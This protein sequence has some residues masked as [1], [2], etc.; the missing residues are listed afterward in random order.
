MAQSTHPTSLLRLPDEL[1][2]A[3]ASDVGELHGAAG[4]VAFGRS[5]KRTHKLT[6]DPTLWKKLCL[7]R[8]KWWEPKHELATKAELPPA[9][10]D[11][12]ALYMERHRIDSGAR[13][14]FD[15]LL[16]TQHKRHHRMWD[17]A[18]QLRDVEDVLQKLRVEAD[19]DADAPLAKKY[20]AEAILGLMHRRQAIE[21][22]M[23]MQREPVALERALGAFDCFVFPAEEGTFEDIERKL[24]SIAQRI[25]EEYDA[26]EADG[27]TAAANFDD[28]SV[29]RKV[30]RI[31][32]FLAAHDHVGIRP[33]HLYHALQNSF[34]GVGLS[35]P[36]NS[37]LPLQ[38][39]AI[40]SAVARRLGVEADPCSFPGHIHLV[41]R[42]PP[43]QS[44]DGEQ[45]QASSSS[46]EADSMYMD[47][48]K[49][50]VEV[51]EDF[52][53]QVLSR[54][55]I[56]LDQHAS[57][58]RPATAHELV[59]RTGRNILTS[60]N[61]LGSLVP[62]GAVP[63]DHEQASYAM[64][65]SALVCS[66]VDMAVAARRQIIVR[67]ACALI[68]HIRTS[69]PW[70]VALLDL[71]WPTPETGMRWIAEIESVLGDLR[72]SDLQPKTPCPRG[73]DGLAA[74]EDVKYRVG[75]YIRHRHYHYQ[76]FI[77]GWDAHCK[78]SEEWKQQMRVMSLS[79]GAAQPFYNVMYVLRNNSYLSFYAPLFLF[80][81]LP[82][83]RPANLFFLSL[84]VCIHVAV[85]A[86]TRCFRF[87][88]S[89]CSR[90][91]KHAYYVA[92]ENIQV[93]SEEPDPAITAL[94]GRYFK[95]W[96]PVAMKFI[97]NMRDEYPDD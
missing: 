20:H 72:N 66:N 60:I 44:L 86:L 78:A 55:G 95:R 15:E 29:R 36:M 12:H 77:V 19:H 34:I 18:S 59:S 56:P 30:L 7:Q 38:S 21:T 63:I 65:W 4:M 91:D 9:Q 13:H 73:G 10:T 70:D 45:K 41:I 48:F 58:L 88:F 8:W 71:V 46:S 76:G 53:R 28:L 23:R 5:C 54:E 47:P 82:P 32:E 52:L 84:F 69:A 97:S 42:A 37:S 35:G 89:I 49:P 31:S 27:A 40:F 81:P 96:D 14:T 26:A 33:G 75:H 50:G 16:A 24:D 1:L 79:G 93:L 62:Q 51:S 64:L 43:D 83:P 11:W 92:E 90:E 61:Q 74:H 2:V 25:R 39:A 85:R 68:D 6:Q 3:I 80:F 94:A 87:S 57:A 22:W 67:M 17:I